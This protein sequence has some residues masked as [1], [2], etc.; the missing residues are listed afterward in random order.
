MLT[1]AGGARGVAAALSGAVLAASSA[2]AGPARADSC[3]RPDLIETIPPDLAAS[4]P[5]NAS[6]F[7][8]Y[9]TNAQ[10]VDEPV[11]MQLTDGLGDDAGVIAPPDAAPT[12]SPDGGLSVPGLP[13]LVSFDSA[14]G[15]LQATPVSPLTPGAAYVV[16]WPSLRGVDTA[17]LGSKADLHFGAGTSADTSAPSFAGVTSVS[18]DVSRENDSCTNRVEERYVFD[19]GLADASDDGGR[20]LLTL[21]VFETS[22]PGIDASAPRPLLVQRIPPAGQGV[23]ITSTDLVG[24]VCFAAIVRDLTGQASTGG[25]PVCVDTVAAPFFYSCGV[26]EGVGRAR[27]RSLRVERWHGAGG[28]GIVTAAAVACGRSAAG[29]PTLDVART[30]AT[31]AA[32]VAGRCAD[33]GEARAC[34]SD[35]GG[36]TRVT[37]TVPPRPPPTPIGW[38]CTGQGGSRRCAARDDVGPFAC[39]GGACEQRL[40]RQPDEG[41]WQCVDDSGATV[42]VGG[43]PAS[44]V[45][46]SCV[47]PGWVC[48]ERRR[49]PDGVRTGGAP[50][51]ASSHDRVCV[52]LSPDVPSGS[53]AGQR[54][55]W[56]YDRRPIRVCV[57]D[58]GAHLL[59][60]ACSPTDPCVVGARCVAGRCLPPAPSADCAIDAD[61]GERARTRCRFGT[62]TEDAP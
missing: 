14:E 45:A 52:D 38:R 42:C 51:R 58:P 6:L 39:D 20:D 23:R 50:E 5:T 18:W 44:G 25:I 26:S 34:W 35:R 37:R 46:R 36:P 43:E 12:P 17:T 30:W 13:L 24:H 22:G 56:S 33:V 3:T 21:V 54:C 32:D 16:H 31:P 7:A 29:D 47:D 19:L 48:G 59:G 2:I 15:L 60:D 49:P 55:R 9:Q 57:R 1:R 62:C 8:R 41:Q 4:V 53:T 28:L 10:W 61:C 11:T 40:P 27:P